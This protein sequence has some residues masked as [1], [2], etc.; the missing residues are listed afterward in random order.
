MFKRT[1]LAT[2]LLVVATIAL[3]G[4]AAAFE[5]RC[6]FDPASCV[7]ER[8][9]E[10]AHDDAETSDDSAV[11]GADTADG[12]DM[13][14][15]PRDLIGASESAPAV[16]ISPEVLDAI[17]DSMTIEV[18]ID[19]LPIDP[20]APGAEPDEASS[21]DGS[22]AGDP[23]SSDTSTAGPVAEGA[24]DLEDDAVPSE[25]ASPV[26]TETTVP[27]GTTADPLTPSAQ[28]Q[29]VAT[30]ELQPASG[31]DPLLAGLIGAALAGALVIAL[32]AAYSSGRRQS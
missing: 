15:A 21:T 11:A 6:V 23:S 14:G 32:L 3:A 1:L 7:I 16:E 10:S 9:A 22:T 18:P 2:A 31:T 12:I 26:P 27:N 13:L 29:A 20:A 4:P 5:P 19:P 25:P 30:A 28:E 24:S 8:I 17:V